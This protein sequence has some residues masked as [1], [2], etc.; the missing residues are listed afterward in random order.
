M[1]QTIHDKVEHE[2]CLRNLGEGIKDFPC[3]LLSKCCWQGL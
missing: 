3:E 1:R 2:D